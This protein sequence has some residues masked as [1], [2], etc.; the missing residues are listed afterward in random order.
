MPNDVLKQ[1]EIDLLLYQ[2]KIDNIKFNI[3]S[4]FKHELTNSLTFEYK[5]IVINEFSSATDI[6]LEYNALPTISFTYNGERK[7]IEFEN[8]NN[9]KDKKKYFLCS[10]CKS[11]IHIEYDKCNK[12][13]LLDDNCDH[14][15]I[16]HEDYINII[17]NILY[18]RAL[19]YKPQLCFN[20]FYTQVYTE[21]INK[22]RHF[23]ENG[24]K[25]IFVIKYF[26]EQI[27]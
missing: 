5:S 3:I 24:I 9:I 2:C 23:E 10:K 6:L 20:P 8:I 19:Q 25:P 4:K 13:F 16:S 18:H 14:V 22:I 26:L 21:L 27:T 15:F 7:L 17:I 12:L 11:I 1:S